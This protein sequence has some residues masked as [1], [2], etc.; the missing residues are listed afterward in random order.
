M[1]GDR[2]D[3]GMAVHP[4]DHVR[5]LEQHVHELLSVDQVLGLPHHG[6]GGVLQGVAVVVAE[7]ERELVLLDHLGEFGLEPVELV[8]RHRAIGT[9]HLVTGIQ[10]EQ[11]DARPGVGLPVRPAGVEVLLGE[12]VPDRAGHVRAVEMGLDEVGGIHE[13]PGRVGGHRHHSGLGPELGPDPGLQA[14]ERRGVLRHPVQVVASQGVRLGRLLATERERT[15]CRVDG[16][17]P[18]VQS[19]V[20]AEDR[21]PGHGRAG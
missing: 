20:V 18:E 1:R 15:Q 19:V 11:P 9:H 8:T 5:V 4:G 16:E 10:A 2:I 14:G 7:Y 21:V 13:A 12:T 3:V 6:F 17:R